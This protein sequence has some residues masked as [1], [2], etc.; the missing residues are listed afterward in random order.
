MNSKKTGIKIGFSVVLLI[1]IAIIFMPIFFKK[2]IKNYL[3]DQYNNSQSEYFLKIGDL[4]SFIFAGNVKMYDISLKNINKASFSS[5][6]ELKASSVSI[7]NVSFFK[8]ITGKGFHAGKV[9]VES[10]DI[11]MSR[12]K[13]SVTEIAVNDSGKGKKPDI[14]LS[15]IIISNPKFS[16]F[17]DLNDS[18]PL[19]KTEHGNI[20]I[21][22]FTLNDLQ[23]S[24]QFSAKN[25]WGELENINYLT[26]DSLYTISISKLN[27]S[28]SD[29]LLSIDS[30]KITPNY[31]KKMFGE[32]AG[33]QTDRISL[34]AYN[35]RSTSFDAKH[36][37]EIQAIRS[38]LISLSALNVEAY[39]DKNI[40]RK[41][42]YPA[43]LQQVISDIKFPIEIKKIEV[44]KGS[45]TY[46][47]LKEGNEKSGYI[48]FDNIKTD[49]LNISNQSFDDTLFVNSTSALGGKGSLKVKLSFPMK[50]GDNSY[51]C[52]G[53]LNGF[54]VKTLNTL[55]PFL[56]GISF[57]S[58]II[59]TMKFD[60]NAKPA[61][62][63]GTL[64]MNY[65]D[66]QI[67][68]VDANS[69][70][71]KGTQKKVLS[72]ILNSFVIKSDVPS[73][74]SKNN[75]SKLYYK[76]DP[77]RFIFNNSLKTIMS[78][79]KRIVLGTND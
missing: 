8:L 1:I 42:E 41:I 19:I 62:A 37:T 77:Q 28:Y 11:I 57:K 71:K 66:L 17:S 15:E 68:A 5:L 51:Q 63:L 27:L 12:V 59:D 6:S 64:Q 36:F 52:H 45:V 18:L 40:E 33:K 50:T 48:S 14:F 20:F 13:K 60:F 24:E 46:E 58:G 4:K 53:E 43:F 69:G 34:Q 56:A 25:L 26:A 32:K 38:G 16:Y 2:Q 29:S 78:G 72:F 22:D 3:I 7:S 30:L 55:V 61:V 54:P 73:E 9:E 75:T 35:L 47:E 65:R 49:I 23:P 10:P 21:G 74:R 44:E 39:R 31:S 76:R 70:S 79:A 67:E